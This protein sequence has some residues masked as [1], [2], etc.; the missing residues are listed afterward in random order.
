MKKFYFTFGYGQEHAGKYV[1]IEALNMG[2]ARQTMVERYGDKWSMCYGES[3]W[4]E[5]GVPQ[6]IKFEYERLDY[7]YIPADD[8][9]EMAAFE[10]EMAKLD[11][12]SEQIDKL[13]E[14]LKEKGYIGSY[15]PGKYHVR[16]TVKMAELAETYGRRIKIAAR[17]CE[18]FPY[19]F[20]FH[21]DG[22]MFYCITT[23]SQHE[24]FKAEMK[25]RGIDY[26]TVAN[27]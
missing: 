20:Y 14:Q 4:H 22:R 27:V 17:D 2:I 25:E 5:G 3:G 23:E 11:E 21:I 18:A 9:E 12:I 6:S 7:I 8:S 13:E 1:E 15:S 19:K 26:E 24:K 16:D 10:K